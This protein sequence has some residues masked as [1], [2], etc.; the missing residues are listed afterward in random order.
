[1]HLIDRNATQAPACLADW[2]YHTQNWDDFGGKCKRELR[3]ALQRMQ[4]QQFIADDADD[5]AYCILGLRCAYCESQ[6]YHG[7][8][9]EHFRRKN[10]AHFPH[11]TFE[12]TNL[13]LACDSQ[14]HCGHYKDRPR[15]PVYNPNDLIKP[16]QHDPDDYLYFHSS[17][18]VRVRN[19]AGMSENDHHSGAETIRVFN[20]DCGPLRGARS[21]VASAYRNKYPTLLDELMGFPENDRNEY[22]TLEIEATRWEP[23]STTI[24][25]FFEKAQ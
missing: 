2:D 12:W 24:R 16:D 10:P 22:I 23:H 7:G 8:H 14:R 3:L 25:H 13:F 1:M 5:T 11:L 15:A 18:E 4:S 19:R 20:L 9:I 17:G 21:K 6:I